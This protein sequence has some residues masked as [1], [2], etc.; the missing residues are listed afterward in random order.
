[1]MHKNRPTTIQYCLCI[2]IVCICIYASFCSASGSPGAASN[3]GATNGATNGVTNGANGQSKS[4]SNNKTPKGNTNT[5]DLCEGNALHSDPTNE[6]GISFMAGCASCVSDAMLNGR[7][8]YQNTYTFRTHCQ[9][10]NWLFNGCSCWRSLNVV[11]LTVYAF[12]PLFIPFSLTIVNIC[13]K[14]PFCPLYSIQRNAARTK[15]M[16]NKLKKQKR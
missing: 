3:S 11:G 12:I 4:G 2:V 6:G 8:C 15:K 16:K 13:L 7:Q 1:M 10:K 9:C 5:G 14:F